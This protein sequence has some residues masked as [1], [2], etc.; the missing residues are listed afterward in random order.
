MLI[1]QTDDQRYGVSFE[2]PFNQNGK[3]STVCRLYVNIGEGLWAEEP[4]AVGDAT[5]S[6]SDN[7]SKASGRKIALGRALLNN[8]EIFPKPSRVKVWETYWRV[9]R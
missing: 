6:K 8:K 1:I 7:F 2:H 4:C 3:R 9:C 5:C